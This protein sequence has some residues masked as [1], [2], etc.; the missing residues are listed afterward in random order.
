MAS[1]L[2]TVAGK[3]LALI[4]VSYHSDPLSPEQRHLF[5]PAGAIKTQP[6]QDGSKT[7]RNMTPLVGPNSTTRP[8]NQH[9]VVGEGALLP[10]SASKS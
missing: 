2:A 3:L 10:K 5:Q 8:I 6:F 7:G 9:Q 1:P 4:S